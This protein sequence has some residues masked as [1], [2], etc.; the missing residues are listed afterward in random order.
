MTCTSTVQVSVDTINVAVA[1]GV[2]AEGN[3]AEDDDDAEVVVL[4]FGLVIDKTND[5]PLETSTLP[6]GSTADLPTA[7]EGDT[8]T[9][10]LAYTLIGDPVTNGIITDVLPVGL[11]YV[12]GSAKGDAQFAFQGYDDA[13]RTLTWTAAKV[14]ESGT[15]SYQATVDA[16]AAGLDPA[17]G[18]RRDH[19]LRRDRAR[20]RRLR[21]LRAHDP[22]R[23]DRDPA[24]HA[25]THRHPRRPAGPGQSQASA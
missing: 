14:S 21:R 25:S 16:G 18:E 13:T 17:P 1:H 3:P 11:T 15:V 22:G 12:A 2:T 19:R 9:F 7:D 10:S 20:L 5:A 23:C 24:D 6:D 4:E 8:V